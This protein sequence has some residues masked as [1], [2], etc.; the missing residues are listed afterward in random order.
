MPADHAQHDQDLDEDAAAP[1]AVH[2]APYGWITWWRV[3]LCRLVASTFFGLV[4]WALVPKAISW[5]PG[6]IVSDSMAPGI[7]RGN[8]V[9][10]SPLSGTDVRLGQ[11]IAFRD[12]E[13]SNDLVVHRVVQE[14]D[15]GTLTTKGDANQ[16]PDSTPLPRDQ[17]VGLGRLQV[18][19]IGWPIIWIQDGQI[20][21]V[22][23]TGVAAVL[24]VMGCFFE[25]TPRPRPAQADTSSSH[26]SD[27]ADD[28]PSQEP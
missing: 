7:S 3:V 10:S 19:W 18:P 14:N 12:P 8:V 23:V 15:D 25:L 17:V 22:A 1:A 9:V 2:A 20:W 28:E 24:V 4:F 13:N 27:Q 11:I 21:A 26:D 6:A 5:I 16:S